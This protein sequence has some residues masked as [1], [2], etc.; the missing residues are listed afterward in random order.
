MYFR[1]EVSDRYRN[2]NLCEIGNEHISFL[3]QDDKKPSTSTV[4]FV[5]IDGIVLM[6]Q[7]QEYIYVPS[8][9]RSHWNQYEI[10]E[11]QIQF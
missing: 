3:Q 4:H 2:N 10:P 8:R 11:S 1:R 7:A 5:N 9:Q 6:V